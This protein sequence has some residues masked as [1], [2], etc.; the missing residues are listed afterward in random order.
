MIM[1]HDPAAK[2]GP[3]ALE[4]E[5][6]HQPAR[7]RRAVDR[8]DLTDQKDRLESIQSAIYATKAIFGEFCCGE[9]SEDMIRSISAL[10]E[11]ALEQVANGLAEDAVSFAMSELREAKDRGEDQ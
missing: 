9:L 2:A 3:L 5:A 8:I 10:A 7:P 1:S 6:D 4:A 11:I